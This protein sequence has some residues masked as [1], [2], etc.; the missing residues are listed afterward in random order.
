VALIIITCLPEFLLQA[1]DWGLLGS[2]RWRSLAYQYGGFWAGLLY[3]WQS[4]YAAQPILMFVTYALLHAGFAHLAGNMLGLGWVGRLLLDRMSS[5]RFLALYAASA[6][7]GAAAFGLLSRSPA[8][9]VGASGAIFGLVGAWVVREGLERRKRGWL[10]RRA[11]WSALQVTALLAGLN[12][13][14]WWLQDGLLA[15]QTHLGGFLTGAVLGL[16]PERKI[17][18]LEKTTGG[19]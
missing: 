9:M 18:N 8:P 17:Q 15:W 7:G 12:L 6:V 3:G 14:V 5:G 13:A 4:N 11:I 1:T 19:T 10:R 16:V 2:P